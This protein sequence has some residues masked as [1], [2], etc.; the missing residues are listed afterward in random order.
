MPSN[1]YNKAGNES[2]KVIIN[3]IVSFSIMFVAVVVLKPPTLIPQ[4][5]PYYYHHHI[6]CTT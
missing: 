2:L 6:N 3:Y 5:E 4:T 1:E